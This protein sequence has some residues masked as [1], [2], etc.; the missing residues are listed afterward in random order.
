ML[1]LPAGIGKAGPRRFFLAALLLAVLS[2]PGLTRGEEAALLQGSVRDEEGRPVS[3][4]LVESRED[5]HGGTTTDSDGRFSLMVPPGQRRIFLSVNRDGFFP[6]YEDCAADKWGKDGRVILLTPL[7]SPQDPMAPTPGGKKPAVPVEIEA[8]AMSYFQNSDS[9]QAVGDVIVRYEEKTLSAAVVTLDRRTEEAFAEGAVVLRSRDDV[10]AGE[11]V[12]IHFPSQTGEAREG[13]M[14]IAQTH[15][16]IRGDRIEKKG[17][18]TYAVENAQATTCDG[19]NPD[20]RLAG[21]TLDVTIDGYGT[22]THGKLY[23]GKLPVIY[24]PYLLFPAKTTRQSGFLFP[25]RLSY[26]QDKLG[27]DIGVPFYWAISKDADAT[28][29]QRYM[30]QRGFQE[31]MELRYAFG[32]A[33]T[34]TIYGDFL[35]D[36]KEVTETSGNISRN[37]QSN[38]K[39]W[40]FYWNQ[41]TRFDPSFY[42][43]ADVAKVSDSWYF[44]DFSSQNYFLDN[45]ASDR[46]QPFKRVAFVGNEALTALDSTVRL[47]KN[48]KLFNLTALAKNTDDYAVATN[49]GTLQKYPEVT[50]TGAKAPL[51]G[52]PVNYEFTSNYD[53][54]YRDAGQRGHYLDF[55][56]TLSLPW[57]GGDY[58]QLTPFAGVQGTFWWRDDKEEDGLAKRGDREV[59]KVG[60]SLASELQRIFPVGG[61]R[62][63][64]IRHALRPEVTYTY[65][66][67]PN[68]DGLPNYGAKVSEQHTVAYSLTNTLISRILEKG[69]KARYLEL[70]RFKLAQTYDLKAA[71]AD[72]VP[73]G[74]SRRPFSDVEMEIDFKPFSYLNLMAR[75]KYNVYDTNWTQANYDLGLNDKRGDTATVTY[76]YTRDSLEEINLLLKAVITKE[77]NLNFTFKRDLLTEKNIEQTYGFD[78]RR[79]CWHIGFSY[80]DRDNDKIYEFRFGIYGM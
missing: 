52:S 36:G 69:G 43:R 80:G 8:D 56:P 19:E 20:W 54:F 27:W 30:S 48:W 5:P 4:A 68:Q 11:R 35:N 46:A 10:L 64:K 28:F 17:E 55:N 75:N 26:S 13:R 31:G 65:I 78:F 22:L 41:E 74:A 33:T 67:N 44:K 37:W 25:H 77:L 24:A 50:L 34:G 76:R 60:A 1:R 42:L 71:A 51:F 39:R 61:P 62:V 40:A 73:P 66:P 63:D 3:G 45:Y 18:A 57:N 12:K 70:L 16:Y 59:Y 6:H 49:D 53:Y 9:Y 14:F 72:G 7:P 58:F 21:K 29:Y 79:Q 47:V 15:L 23:A 38:Q 32:D 2:F